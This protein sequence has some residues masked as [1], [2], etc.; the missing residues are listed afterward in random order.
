[1]VCIFIFYG[2]IFLDAANAVESHVLG[3]FYCVGTPWSNHLTSW[4]DEAALQVFFTFRHGF[5]KKPA[6]FVV[7]VRVK[8]VVALYGNHALGR[9]SEKK[10]HVCI[11]DFVFFACKDKQIRWW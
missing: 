7:V 6:E 5:T 10:N 1:M 3:Y 11:Y 2:E 9:G 4:P 8:F